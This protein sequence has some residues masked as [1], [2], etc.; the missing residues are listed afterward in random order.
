M[1][2]VDEIRDV[3]QIA[4]V[5]TNG[6]RSTY[7]METELRRLLKQI[8]AEYDAT[9]SAL[10]AL[11]SGTSRHDFINARMQNIDGYRK[12]LVELVGEAEAFRLLLQENDKRE[13]R[14][15]KG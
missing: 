6:K 10:H 11:S 14:E 3:E 7:Y 13:G 1:L 2:T 15:N 9:Y 4:V 12:E 8:E 5:W